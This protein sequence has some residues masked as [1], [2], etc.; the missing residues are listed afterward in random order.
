MMSVFLTL[1]FQ[2]EMQYC[3]MFT[4]QQLNQQMFSLC[5]KITFQ[6]KIFDFFL[7][8]LKVDFFFTTISF[9]VQKYGIFKYLIIILKI[10]C[11]AIFSSISFRKIKI[12]FTHS[13][14][15]NKNVLFV[16]T[17]AFQKF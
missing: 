12:Y 4:K 5:K 10:A 13:S 1:F 3:L 16:L 2:I 7:K 15:F 8:N 17:V 14:F 6:S 11:K 9:F